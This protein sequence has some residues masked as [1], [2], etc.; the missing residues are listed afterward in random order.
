VPTDTPVPTNTPKPTRAPAPKPAAPKQEQPKAQEAAAPAAAPAQSQKQFSGQLV[1]WWP[2]CG[3][4]GAKGKVLD[5]SGNP[6]NGLR[7][8]LWTDGWD[9]AYSLVSGVGLSYGPG[10]WDLLLRA[11]QT[12][13]FKIAVSDWQ[14]GPDQYQPVESDVV[15]LEFDYNQDTCQP[16]G[17]GH[18][19]AEVI[20]TRNF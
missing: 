5:K 15:N 9:G 18:Q 14:T 12:G 17:A 3:S 2:N 16:E 6:V 4:T 19:W 11:G 1:K 20:F 10:D 8:R 13:N 7:I